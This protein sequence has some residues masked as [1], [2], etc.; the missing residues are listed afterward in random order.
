[1]VWTQ[2]QEQV[3]EAPI[4][5]R[6]V[7]NANAG[8]G[9]TA[10]LVARL[11]HLV[12]L[13]DVKPGSELL[14]LTFSRAAVGVVRQRVREAGGDASYVHTATFDAFA[15]QQLARF[16]PEGA[17]RTE[18]YDGRVRHATRL[19]KDQAAREALRVYRHVLVDEVQDLLED[20][21]SFVG[22]IL[23]ASGAGFTLFI[24]RAQAIYDFQVADIRNA[25]TAETLLAILR[26]QNGDRLVERTF[27]RNFRAQ[28]EEAKLALQYGPRLAAPQPDYVQV[29][30]GLEDALLSVPNNTLGGL[31][32]RCQAIPRRSAILCRTN[33]EALVISRELQALGVRHVVARAATDR[34]VASW[35]GAVFASAPF[36]TVTKSRVLELVECRQDTPPPNEAWSL[37]KRLDRRNT[38]DLDLREVANRI[39]IGY[40][41]DE[42]TRADEAS[43]VVSTV[44]RAKGLE[45][46]RV[47]VVGFED[48]GA[49]DEPSYPEE[50]RLLYVALTRS[51][52]ELL[53]L[54]AA[55]VR[56]FNSKGNFD[57]RWVQRVGW[58][59]R[60]MAVEVRGT[61]VHADDPAGA[62]FLEGVDPVATQKYLDTTVAIGDAVTLRRVRASLEGQPRAFYAIDHKGYSIGT[63]SEAFGHALFRL[64]G[65]SARG[66]PQEI[67]DLRIEAVDTVGGTPAAS[68]NSGLGRSGIWLR[69][70]VSGLGGLRWDSSS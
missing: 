27:T 29:G 6:L 21:V 18:S 59:A 11:A 47:A 8:T 14:V 57:D 54:P 45:F 69:A 55:R 7:V 28:S 10:V 49:E 35:V 60:A 52:D 36:A 13:G 58:N 70:R 61:D 16:E 1:M 9:K 26:G 34:C 5:A 65:R 17:W 32:A 19:L 51:H 53:H 62:Y 25:M 30:Y 67:R 63:T 2:E 50:V 23:E 24:D 44:H 15:T 37:L 41:P 64:L 12:Q 43:L 4:D 31:V 48:L 56:W 38:N 3:I 42:L 33:G 39:R 46:D 22:A 68:S 66:F 20:R 40:V